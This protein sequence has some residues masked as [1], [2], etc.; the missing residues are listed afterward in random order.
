[1]RR[2]WQ[3]QS[4]YEE[5]KKWERFIAAAFAEL[6]LLEKSMMETYENRNLEEKVQ[7]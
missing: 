7:S 1:M 5:K 6:A 4:E 3:R 2:Y